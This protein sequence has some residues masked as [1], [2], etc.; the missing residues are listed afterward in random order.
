[1]YNFANQAEL[2]YHFDEARGEAVLP[3]TVVA[4]RTVEIGVRDKKIQPLFP[5]PEDW[6]KQKKQNKLNVTI[7][8]GD[9][10]EI[11]ATK[12]QVTEW[13]DPKKDQIIL[14][15]I[16]DGVPVGHATWDEAAEWLTNPNYHQL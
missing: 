13:L 7:G 12:S 3:K 9:P 6:D 2:A 4:I 1:M 8:R 15:L 5:E 11:A 14:M 16:E 10:E